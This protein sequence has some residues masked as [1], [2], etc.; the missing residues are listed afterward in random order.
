MKSHKELRD[1]Y[2]QMKFPMGVFQI[3][4]VSNNRVFIDSSTDMLSKW[5]RHKT[6]L[7]FGGHRNKALQKDWKEYGEG[8][9]VFEILT[10]LKPSEGQNGSFAR[11]LKLLETLILEEL[12]LPEGMRY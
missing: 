11:E 4:N 7:R 2:K 3:K 8:N 12:A 5:N 10:E 1:A 6:E 9:F